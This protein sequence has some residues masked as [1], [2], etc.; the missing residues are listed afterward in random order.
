MFLH[1]NDGADASSPCARAHG[2]VAEGLVRGSGI[3][4]YAYVYLC[5]YI[6]IHICVCICI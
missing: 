5:T 3:N 1:V 2:V 4:I 6:Y